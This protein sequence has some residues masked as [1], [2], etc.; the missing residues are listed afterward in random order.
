MREAAMTWEIGAF[1]ASLLAYF[2][3]AIDPVVGSSLRVRLARGWVWLV[4]SLVG[5]IRGLVVSD[6]VDVI[7]RGASLAVCFAIVATG[8]RPGLLLP[9]V[10]SSL[11]STPRRL[12][13][14]GVAATWLTAVFVICY[15]IVSIATAP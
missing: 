3:S 4:L 6:H 1:G 15:S 12:Q 10:N 7:F 2:L 8:F 13:V 9:R 14:R 11:S 5:L